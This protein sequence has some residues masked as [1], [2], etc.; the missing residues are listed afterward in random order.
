MYHIPFASHQTH[1][2]VAYPSVSYSH[3][4]YYQARGAVGVLSE[5][6]SSRLFNEIRE[7]RGLCYSVFASC[8][9]TRE[10]GSVLCY[11]STSADRA[12]ETLDVLIGQL[13]AL[14]HG[15]NDDELRRV[16][17]Q[18]R[19]GLIMQQESCR[20]R[21]GSIAGDWFYLRRIQT[22]EEVSQQINQ[23]T[24][25]SINDY[26]AANAPYEFDVVSLGPRPLE[27]N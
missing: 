19:S 4:D 12:Q 17:V 6:L 26:L 25:Q 15:V 2:A 22:L 13:R 9:S 16:K 11:A 14:S 3:P 20:S 10:R 1:I 5:G 21:A 18:I 23:L 7:K 8:H 27:L 24:I